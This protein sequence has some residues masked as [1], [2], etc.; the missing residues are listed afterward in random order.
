ML[1]R[2]WL[3]DRLDHPVRDYETG[4]V[5]DFDSQWRDQ[6]VEP[7]RFRLNEAGLQEPAFQKIDQVLNAPRLRT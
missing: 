1:T 7:H 6:K 2:F 3:V 4:R 5:R